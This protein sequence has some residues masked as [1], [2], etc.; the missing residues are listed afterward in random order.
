MEN[1]ENI[2]NII[3]IMKIFLL[4]GRNRN[5]SLFTKIVGFLS[6]KI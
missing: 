6:M 3:E 1:D 4:Y 5:F 2:E